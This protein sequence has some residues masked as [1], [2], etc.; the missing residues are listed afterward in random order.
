MLC[1]QCGQ[2]LQDHNRFCP[3]CGTPAPAPQ[4]KARRWPAVLALVLIFA[5][6]FSVFW[7]MRPDQGPVQDN[8]TPWFTLQDGILY[9]DPARY[10]GG[11]ELTVPDTIGGQTVTTI[12]DNCFAYCDQL[13]II[14]LP[15]T[16]TTIGDSAFYGCSSLR[17]IK[18]PESLTSIGSYAF[19]GCVNL[20]AVCIPHALENF[21]D[22]LFSN[23]HK[24]VYFFY[25]G[26]IADWYAL[27]LGNLQRDSYVY[28]ADGIYPAV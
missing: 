13:V 25:S 12:S 17:G 2:S 15:E 6:G 23:C 4:N 21:G 22:Q 20:E 24:L 1:T 19:G 10:T 28:C 14:H 16:V 27:P 8:A 11:E 7:L 18:L 26:H 9:F 3:M 5:L